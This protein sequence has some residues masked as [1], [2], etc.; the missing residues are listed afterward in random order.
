MIKVEIKADG[1]IHA[2][3]FGYLNLISLTTKRIKNDI[4]SLLPCVRMERD[5]CLREGAA[6]YK[7]CELVDVGITVK[8]RRKK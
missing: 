3:T 8:L 5:R 4:E 6:C 1:S 2:Q 7:N